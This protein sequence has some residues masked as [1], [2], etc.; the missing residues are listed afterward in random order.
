MHALQQLIEKA[1][2]EGGYAVAEAK[3]FA[4]FSRNF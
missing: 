4:R 1:G 3:F 2:S